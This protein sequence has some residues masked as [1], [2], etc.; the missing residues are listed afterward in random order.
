VKFEI[1]LSKDTKAR[2]PTWTSNHKSAAVSP[3][4]QFDVSAS[5]AMNSSTD[6][7]MTNRGFGFIQRDDGEL[8]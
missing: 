7:G 2:R 3:D 6:H 4:A 5:R 1:E 8:A